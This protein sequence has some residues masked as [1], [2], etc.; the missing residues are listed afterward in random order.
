M[1]PMT[2]AARPS[3]AVLNPVLNISAK[4][5]EAK[6]TRGLAATIDGATYIVALRAPWNEP[7]YQAVTIQPADQ[8]R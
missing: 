8:P 4:E 5:W 7:V 1:P 3:L 6:R 2:N